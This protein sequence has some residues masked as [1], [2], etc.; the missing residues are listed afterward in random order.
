IVALNNIE[1]VVEK[2]KKSKDAEIAKQMLMKDYSLSEIQAKSILEMRLQRLA[3]L[4]QQKIRDDHKS[5]VIL[6]S[7]LKLILSSEEKIKEIIKN[8]LLELKQIY[9]DPRRTQIEG[10][11][12]EIIETED[13][14]REEDVVVTLSHAGYIKRISLQ[15]YRE[16]NRGGK[17][18]IAATTKEE[19]FVEDLFV[20]ST[21]AS[22]LVFTN[23]GIVH[24]L[25]VYQL[26]EASRQ[27]KGTP[28]VNLV[29]IEQGEKISAVIP[30][31]QFQPNNYLLFC[32]KKG[33]VKKTA[34]EEYSNPRKGGIIAVLL[35]EGD[36]LIDVK[37]ASGADEIIIATK[38]GNAVRFSEQDVRPTGRATHGVIGITLKEDQ[39]IGMVNTNEGKS[40]LTVTELGYGKRTPVDDYRL[41]SRGGVGVI[42]IKITDKNG[43]VAAIKAV[44]EN[45]QIMLVTKQGIAIRVPVNQI[46]EIGRNTQGV[47]IIKLEQGD[48]VTACAKIVV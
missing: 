20:A 12:V 6:I 33:I 47:R 18:I 13:L 27:S 25:K 39:V 3:S 10:E 46:S 43:K 31:R 29:E 22:L 9:G 41:I 1:P 38:N 28:I 48:N 42:N 16:Q 35:D 30:V 19:D 26:P 45:D 40:L 34:L 14:I 7:E 5:A 23:K 21:H 37:L 8:E 32:T 11:E 4:E 15:E 24:W 2:I 17:G 44:N 36:D